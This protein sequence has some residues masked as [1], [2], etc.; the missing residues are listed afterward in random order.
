MPD[1]VGG[2]ILP[3]SIRL[4]QIPDN[5]GMHTKGSIGRAWSVHLITTRPG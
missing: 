1:V 3:N 4:P 2:G 5:N